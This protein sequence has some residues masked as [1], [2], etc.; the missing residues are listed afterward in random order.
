[1]HVFASDMELKK[2]DDW[3]LEG[4]YDAEINT[5]Q[6]NLFARGYLSTDEQNTITYYCDPEME[7]PIGESR[8]DEEFTS[9]VFYSENGDSINI[10]VSPF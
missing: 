7:I 9:G 10:A 1:M 4:S 2:A 3:F 5:E 6:F 8:F